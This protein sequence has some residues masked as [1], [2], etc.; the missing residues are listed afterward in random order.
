[1]ASCRRGRP[2]ADPGPARE[3][4]REILSER[5]FQEPDLPRPFK[6]PLDWL[7]DR[8]EDLGSWLSGGFDDV[9]GVLP[10]GGWVVWGL[11]IG[12]VAVLGAVVARAVVVRRAAVGFGRSK[13]PSTTEEDPREL[14][15]AAEAAERAGAFA[16]AVRLRFRAGVLRL[17]AEAQTTGAIAAELHSPDFEALGSSHDAIAYG[18]APAEAAD[19]EAARERWRAVLAR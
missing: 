2:V 17:D 7:G 3:Q 12:L 5:R 6:T 4:A 18:G 15:R 1:M 14:E 11:L 16:E 19:A 10:G 9:D 8:V 13:R